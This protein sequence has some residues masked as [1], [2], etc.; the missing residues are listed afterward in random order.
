M[1]LRLMLLLPIGAGLASMAA[2]ARVYKIILVRGAEVPEIPIKSFQAS[3][4]GKETIGLIGIGIGVLVF[5][6]LENTLL[7]QAGMQR[8]GFS[9]LSQLVGVAGSSLSAPLYALTIK[10]VLMAAASLSLLP[11]AFFLYDQRYWLLLIIGFIICSAYLYSSK[12]IDK[13]E[14]QTLFEDYKKSNAL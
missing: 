6:I 3:L 14:F 8:L 13:Q 5:I 7:R 9:Q 2:V 11:W 4:A 10:A 12:V 1:L